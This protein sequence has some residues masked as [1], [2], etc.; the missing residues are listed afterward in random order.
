MAYVSNY[1]T[2][3]RKLKVKNKEPHNHIEDQN[4]VNVKTGIVDKHKSRQTMLGI[5]LSLK[6]SKHVHCF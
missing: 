5:F 3:G 4:D 1:S 6:K 2:K